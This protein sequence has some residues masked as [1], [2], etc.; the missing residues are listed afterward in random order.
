SV[1]GLLVFVLALTAWL[2]PSIAGDLYALARRLPAFSDQLTGLYDRLSNREGLLG[3]L[4][5][6]RALEFDSSSLTPERL[7]TLA[8]NAFSA[9]LPVLVSCGGFLVTLLANLFLVVMLA[10][11]F[12]AEPGAYVRA[13]LYLVPK[14]RQA[15]LEALWSTL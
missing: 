10:I 3:Q 8:N 15:R 12:V 6:P 13:S 1:V 14:G 5:P 2:I 11:F 9:G 4:M 7:R